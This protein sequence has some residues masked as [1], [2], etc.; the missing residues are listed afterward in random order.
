MALTGK[1]KLFIEEY[2]RCWNASEAARRAGYAHP[3]SEG[4]RL[5][6]NDEIRDEVAARLS[7]KAMEADEVLGRLGD[8]ARAT[9]EDFITVDEN[10]E[11]YIDLRKAEEAGKLHLIKRLWQDRDGNWRLE[12]H[13]AQA[14]LA[15]IGRHLEL[16]V[17]RTKVETDTPVLVRLDR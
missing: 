1:R 12:L 9:I 2:L 15:L 3:G 11:T 6:K 17:D 16:F 7:A 8:M 10:G 4:H 14:A 5:L 13:D